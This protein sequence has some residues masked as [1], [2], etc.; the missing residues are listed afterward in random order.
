MFSRSPE[1]DSVSGSWWFFETFLMF[2]IS[3]SFS[4]KNEFSKSKGNVFEISRGGLSVRK[5]AIFWD[6][7]T[8]LDQLNISYE[9]VNAVTPKGTKFH[10]WAHQ[11]WT[12]CQEAGDFLR[13]IYSTRPAEHFMWTCHCSNYKGNQVSLGAGQRWLQ[14]R[15]ALKSTNSLRRSEQYL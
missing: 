10:F 8:R 2:S 3:W 6:L 13:L 1:V 7:F 15:P 14:I 11:R 5:L 4:R 12:Q 9:H